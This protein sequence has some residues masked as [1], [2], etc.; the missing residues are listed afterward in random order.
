MFQVVVRWIQYLVLH[1]RQIVSDDNS[2]LINRFGLS[3]AKSRQAESLTFSPYL[4]PW[5]KEKSP[6][7]KSLVGGRPV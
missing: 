5:R 3:I 2:V 1:I 6:L 4:G 7:F